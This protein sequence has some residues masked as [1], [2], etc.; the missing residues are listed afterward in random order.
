MPMRRVLPTGRELDARH[1]YSRLCGVAI[2]NNG[3]RR[4]R[5]RTFELDTLG[6]LEYA[7]TGFLCV[8]QC[9]QSDCAEGQRKK[10][11]S[12]G[13]EIPLVLGPGIAVCI[14]S[15]TSSVGATAKRCH[16]PGTPLR[17]CMSASSFAHRQPTAL[18]LH[19]R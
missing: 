9:G 1:E 15:I 19:E 17:A 2:Q 8:G 4:A 7:C 5:L 16:S 11:Q 3:L 12:C 6:E 14:Y 10:G 18:H 13:H